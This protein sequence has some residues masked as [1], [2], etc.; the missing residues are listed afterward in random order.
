ME[1][2]KLLRKSAPLLFSAAVLSLL[3]LIFWQRG[4]MPRI[5]ETFHHLEVD[6]NIQKFGLIHGEGGESS[7]E[8]V[9]ESAGYLREEGIFI[10]DNPVITYHTRGSSGPLLIR[11]SNGRA[12]QGDNTI[13]LWPDVQATQNGLTVN[14]DKA[15]YTGTD[16]LILLEENVVFNGRGITVNSSQAT[17]SLE[18]ERIKATGE[19]K[20]SLHQAG[21]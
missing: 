4:P 16:N 18:D 12:S 5:A 20:T 9:S 1:L 14:S 21:P 3:F 10:L 15:T 19:V 7:W 6:M 11:A 13:H 2:A 17:I 8:L